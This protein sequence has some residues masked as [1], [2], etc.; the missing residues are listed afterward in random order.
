MT[1]ETRKQPSVYVKFR[2]DPASDLLDSIRF[3][4]RVSPADQLVGI[5]VASEGYDGESYHY[6]AQE[7]M[8]AETMIAMRTVS[9][10]RNKMRG[11]RQRIRGR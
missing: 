11:R 8:D 1:V 9:R 4:K 3:L 5:V 7:V 6:C 10:S 2:V